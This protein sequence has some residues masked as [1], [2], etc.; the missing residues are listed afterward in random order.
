MDHLLALRMFVRIA[1][2]GTFGKAA[3]QLALPRST[4]SKLI[5]DLE[6]HL[7]TKLIQRTTRS[8]TV[9]PEGA[10]YYERARRLIVDLEEMDAAVRQNRAQPK[11]RL[12]VDVGSV[13]ANRILLPA[14]PSFHAAYPDIELRLGVSDRPTDLISEGVDC[15]IRGGPLADTTLIAR[16]LCEM[17]FVTCCSADYVA[18]HG[19][20]AHPRDL[21]D[22][23]RIVGYFSALTGKTFPLHFSRGDDAIEIHGHAAVAVNESTAHIGALAAGLGIGQTFAWFVREGLA[24]GAMVRVLEDWKQ[25]H[26]ALHI[27]YPSNRHLNA[28]VRVFVDWAVQLFA[29]M[30]ERTPMARGPKAGLQ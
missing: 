27:L 28:K 15:V 8:V 12:R 29:A 5:L 17:A 13:L 14:L 2:A 23:H 18:R 20:P 16:K 11:G 9:T 26:Q 4:A 1:E 6:Q 21:E 10:Q 30:D 7:G 3:D 24:S 25:P 22:R 19:Q